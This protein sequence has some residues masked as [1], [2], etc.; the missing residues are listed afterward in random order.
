M[1]E[2]RGTGGCLVKYI[3]L[4]FI[5][6]SRTITKENAEY[7]QSGMTLQICCNLWPRNAKDRFTEQSA[8]SPTAPAC[9]FG[10]PAKSP[11]AAIKR[12]LS[13]E[14]KVTETSTQLTKHDQTESNL[15]ILVCRLP[16]HSKSRETPANRPLLLMSQLR[17]PPR[18]Y[19]HPN[20]SSTEP[21]TRLTPARSAEDSDVSVPG[22]TKPV[23]A[24]V[25]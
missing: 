7:I 8:L 4:P 1:Q 14:I 2:H 11:P 18:F 5:K 20:T 17:L 15:S 19:I 23:P 16:K 24:G 9:H 3:E 21:R 12:V 6:K 10:T 22:H 25:A 13:K